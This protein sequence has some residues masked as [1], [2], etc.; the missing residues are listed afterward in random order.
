MKYKKACVPR[1]NYL[2][3]EGTTKAANRLIFVHARAHVNMCVLI[4][5][6]EKS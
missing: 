2:E 1:A 4:T 3:Y 6:I 5:R